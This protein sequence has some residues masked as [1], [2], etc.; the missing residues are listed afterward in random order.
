VDLGGDRNLK[1]IIGL[2]LGPTAALGM[3]LF[4]DLD[5]DNAAITRTASVAILMAVWWI[6]EAIPIPATALLPVA[7]FPLLGIMD[8]KAVATT[9]FND[10]IFLFIGGFIMA[11]AMQRWNLHRRVAL[12][13]VRLIGTGPKRIVLSF[14]VATAFLSM[15]ISNTATTMMMVPIALS[16]ILKFRE[17]DS[18]AKINSF[19]VT[20]LLGIAY[21]ASIGGMATLIGT[22][23][24]LALVRIFAITYPEAPDITFTTWLTFALPLSVLF[25]AIAWGTLVLIFMP[26][27]YEFTK[28]ELFKVEYR[29]LGKVTYEEKIVLLLSTLMGLLWLFR[30]DIELGAMTLPGWSSLWSLPDFID[31]GTVAI[32]VALLLF[33]IP[34]RSVRGRLMNWETASRLHWGIVILFGGG[35]ALAAGFKESGLSAWVADGLVGLGSVVPV[36]QVAGTCTIVTLL[37][38]LT[39][40]TATTQIVLPLLASLAQAIKV[41]PLLLMI[42]AT[43]S[44]SCAFMLPVATPPNAIVFGSGEVKMADMVKGGIA[45]NLLGVI[46]ITCLIFMVGLSVF[47]IDLTALPGWV[48]P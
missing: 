25:L 29:K 13:T 23:P 10:V 14:M 3:L 40:N 7:L 18:D 8:G 44:A 1:Q 45:M 20:L 28:P 46:L 19:A 9:Y 37:T 30:L 34:S 41:N 11:L 2:W 27:R 36:F 21:S 31:D 22:P 47:A 17:S 15:W 32:A 33:I 16:V 26:R 4:V 5:P 48:S 6:T 42:P 38:E 39:S 24:N 43:L 35:F 12:W